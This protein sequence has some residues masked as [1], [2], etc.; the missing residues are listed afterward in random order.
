MVGV[1]KGMAVADQVDAGF[2]YPTDDVYHDPDNQAE[3]MKE[4][5]GSKIAASK[6]NNQNKKI[7]HTGK[8]LVASTPYPNDN[9]PTSYVMYDTGDSNRCVTTVPVATEKP[10]SPYETSIKRATTPDNLASAAASAN[11]LSIVGLRSEARASGFDA[12]DPSHYKHFS[13]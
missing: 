11:Q 13:G 1:E 4:R 3:L 10:L 6:P 12:V 2:Y 9:R 5:F 8:S 7:P